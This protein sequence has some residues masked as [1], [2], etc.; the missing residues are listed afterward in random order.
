MNGL[1]FERPSI[2][3]VS[4]DPVA[5]P[6]RAASKSRRI[7]LAEYD[8][9]A[10]VGGGQTI[11]RSIIRERPQDEFF[12][13]AV[14]E[15]QA[16]PRP[17]NAHQI[18]F[19]PMLRANVADLP[20]E[21][22]HFYDV[23]M[24]ASNIAASV[25]AALGETRFDCVDTPDY[26][27]LGLFLRDAM[28]RRGIGVDQVVLALHGTLSSAMV[29]GWPTGTDD[30]RFLAALRLREHMQF[31]AADARYAISEAYAEKWRT[32]APLPIAHVDPVLLIGRTQPCLARSEDRAPDLAFIGRRERRKG[33][34]LFIDLAWWL[35]ER[36]FRKALIIGPDGTNRLGQGSTALLNE[37]ARKRRLPIQLVG[38]MS[39]AQLGDILRSKTL[40]VLPSRY[41][42]FNLVALEALLVG[43]PVVVS[44][45]SGIARVIEDR[46]PAFADAVI[47]LDCGRHAGIV[48]S[49]VLGDYDDYRRRL[50]E[51]IDAGT[52][53][54]DPHGM[55]A[56]YASDST[57]DHR[58]RSALSDL[59]DRFYLFNRPRRSALSPAMVE[60]LL[61]QSPIHRLVPSRVRRD[62]RAAHRLFRAYRTGGLRHF[63]RSEVK[64]ILPRL[65]GYGAKSIAQ[66][67]FAREVRKIRRKLLRWPDSGRAQIDDKLAYLTTLVNDR[68]VDRIRLFSEMSRLE[69]KRGNDLIAATY[70]LRLMRWMGRDAFGA[71]PGV[72]R[73]LRHAGYAAEAEAAEAMFGDPARAEAQCRAL[74]DSQFARHRT[75]PHLP[76]ESCDDRRTTG[77]RQ[78]CAVIVSLYRAEDKLRSFM[79][80]LRQQTLMQRGEVEV[81]FVD[82][83][84][85]TAE[86]KVF[87]ELM[88]KAPFPALYARSHERETIQAAWNRGIQL[89]RAPYLAFLGVDEG[90]HPTCLELLADELDGAPDI[91]WVMADSIVTEVDRQGRY[92]RDVMIYDR[93]GYRHDWH[94]LDCTFLSYV[95]GLYRR[96]IHD[97]FG[98]YDESFRA[99]GDTEFKNRILPHIASRHVPRTLGVFNNYPGERT[100]Q[101]PRAEIEDLRAWYLHRTV[102]GVGYAFDSAPVD[103]VATLLRDT[104]RYRKCYCYHWS[105]D[106]DLALSLAA[107]LA[108]RSDADGLRDLARAISGVIDTYRKFEL[109]DIERQA[110]RLRM[111]LAA[112]FMRV[113]RLRRQ[114]QRLFS[115]EAPPAYHFFNDNR[116]EQHWWSWSG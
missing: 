9:F 16:T 74:L 6:E 79:E 109:V 90:I 45:R 3:T 102:A 84:S 52:L 23:Y 59:A 91:D 39:P 18:P 54:A 81:I 12:Y 85:P 75:K 103:R 46:L 89:S 62:I 35:P 110:K 49:R 113:L 8:L 56:V 13:F 99:A 21:T 19:R 96:T 7:L 66:L 57:F 69:R 51:A 72:V 38:S 10:K 93:Q 88:G 83:G 34:D 50:C 2:S 101:H 70:G 80:M 76:L 31:R 67:Y 65:T 107:H 77:H 111:L 53:E 42:Q 33:P 43:C 55:A 60:L 58:T 4:P 108:R 40:V 47:D 11:Y 44:R 97:R 73:T 32:Y 64:A 28:E 26:R 1:L 14:D 92:D 15:D 68:F 63:L 37:A 104:L 114:H 87:R 112:S 24:E 61:R 82:S 48:I 105:T 95:G 5:L 20:A 27:Q 86:Y 29:D 106:L 17:A 98:Y 116:Y 115:L 78:R 94:Y 36:S 71:L 30:S 100:T 25:H 41:D 22:R